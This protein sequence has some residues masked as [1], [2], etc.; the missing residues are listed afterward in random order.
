MPSPFSMKP[1]AA[2]HVETG[3]GDVSRATRHQE[4]HRV[5][6][7]KRAAEPSQRR[8]PYAALFALHTLHLFPRLRARLDATPRDRVDAHAMQRRLLRDGLRE[9]DDSP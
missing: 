5:A 2:A 3:A 6:D 8:Q 1:R 4:A 9:R 7:F